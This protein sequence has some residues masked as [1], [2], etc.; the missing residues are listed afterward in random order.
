[1]EETMATYAARAMLAALVLLTSSAAKADDK[2]EVGLVGAISM[3]HWPLLIGLKK[4]Y[5][6]A[7][8]VNLDLIHIQSSGGGLHQLAARSIDATISAAL[9]E[10]LYAISKG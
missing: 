7:E 6:A 3:T 9:P 2:L 5:Y 1:M 10:P 8:H 4:G